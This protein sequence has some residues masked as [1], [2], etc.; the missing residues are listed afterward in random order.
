MLQTKRYLFSTHMFGM[1]NY[2]IIRTT[3]HNFA[4]IICLKL[5]Y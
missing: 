5:R 4:A 3:K 2:K 1:F